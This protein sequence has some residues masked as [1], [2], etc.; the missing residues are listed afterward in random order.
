MEHVGST[1]YV[2]VLYC[3]INM[4]GPHWLALPLTGLRYESPFQVVIINCKYYSMQCILTEDLAV[5][6]S[7]SETSGS[8]D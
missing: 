4:R 1:M 3:T 6:G 2:Y 8:K 7:E 5:P